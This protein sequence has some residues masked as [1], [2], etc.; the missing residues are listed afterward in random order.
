MVGGILML[1]TCHYTN[2]ESTN[3]DLV[4]DLVY[5][6]ARFFSKILQGTRIYT[7]CYNLAKLCNIISE[8]LLGLARVIS[9]H[10]LE[11]KEIF[12]VVK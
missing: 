7:I 1:Y 3:L 11:V 6:L 4:K 8:I 5:D 12:V 9:Y 2:F 10:R